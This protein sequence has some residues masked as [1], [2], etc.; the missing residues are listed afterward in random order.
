G[1]E[2]MSTP[3]DKGSVDLLLRLGMTRMK[4][5]SGE[6]TNFPF[7]RDLVSRDLPLIVSTGMATLQEVE[8]AVAF[9]AETR[10]AMGFTAPMAEVVTVLHC[11]SNY[12]AA[13]ADVNLRAMQTIATATGLPV[14][15][16][17]HTLG[18][19]VATAAVALGARVIEK[20]FTLGRDRPG[21]DHAA[22]LEPA[23]LT[24]LV[25]AVRDVEAALGDGLKTPSA[26][27][28]PNRPIARRSL[29]A[30]R[31]VAAGEAW[32][33]GAVTA[34]RPAD[35]LSPMTWWDIAGRTAVRAYAVDDALAAEELP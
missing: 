29:V 27:E 22:S 15:Y 31:P 11:T 19:A 14:G 17:D 4:V 28:L 3:F 12:P 7:L 18:I 1:I 25:R 23:E 21:P 24:A 26:A 10:A 9:I 2:F 5:P 13:C 34:K 8:E 32:T 16:S 20:H 6:I 35:G 33:A 30:A